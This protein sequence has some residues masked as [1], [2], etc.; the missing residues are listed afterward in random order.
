LIAGGVNDECEL[1][2][3]AATFDEL[4]TQILDELTA[5]EPEQKLA[6]LHNAF[7]RRVLTGVYQRDAS[8]IRQTLAAGHYNCLSS[9]ALLF[10]LSE[11]A[12]LDAQ[13]RLQHGHV[14][15]QAVQPTGAVVIEPGAAIATQPVPAAAPARLLSQSQLL[16]K[17]FYNRGIELLERQHFADGLTLLAS[18][19]RLDPRDSDARTNFIAG[20]NNWAAACCAA[21]HYDQAATLITVGLRLAPDFAPLIANQQLVRAKLQAK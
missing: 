11:A 5:T 9:A 4:K 16:A 7:R 10:A 13:I 12:G 14:N 18:S 1:C 19:I 20:V 21:G 17:F 8:D 6:Q 15:L 3:W 2:I